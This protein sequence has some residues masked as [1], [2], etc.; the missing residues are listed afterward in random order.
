[1]ISGLSIFSQLLPKKSHTYATPTKQFK[2][3]Y[4]RVI[5][6]DAETGLWISCIA[7]EP[8]QSVPKSVQSDIYVVINEEPRHIQLSMLQKYKSDFL[9]RITYSVPD[10]IIL[11]ESGI[12][13]FFAASPDGIV[14]KSQLGLLKLSVLTSAEML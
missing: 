10:N 11:R 9:W 8:L 2:W 1:M 7:A 14:M 4:C 13:G 5:P 6:V 12:Y 3:H